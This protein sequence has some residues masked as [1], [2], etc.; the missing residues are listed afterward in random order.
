[1]SKTL[2]S[3]AVKVFDDMVKQAYQGSAEL[4]G[5]ITER[6]NVTGDTYNFR[7]IGKGIANQKASADDVTPMDVAHSLQVATLANWLAPEYTD[8]FDQAE[9]NFDEKLELAQ[10]IAHAL[11]RR[12]DQ[13]I[14]DAL[15]ASTPSTTTVINSIGA[16]TTLNKGKVL[17]AATALNKSG[18]S[19]TDG[20]RFA[21]VT[22]EGLEGLLSTLEVVS[23]D[24]N[25]VQGLINGDISRWMGFDFR[26]IND[27]SAEEGGL[28]K[29][30]STVDSWFWHKDAMGCAIGMD[31]MTEVNYVP[32]KTAW[33]SNGFLKAG[34]VNR[35]PAGIVKVQYNV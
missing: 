25:S 24:Y 31:I 9:V 8:I 1:M 19:R 13:I 32:S 2:S 18:V 29:A 14:I 10:V 16:D 11:G 17:A 6:N 26:I 22:A 5:T 34:A 4:D 20:N 33:L 15:D 7:L 30:G 27:R 3:V 28:T 23:S 21:A 35:D 12:K